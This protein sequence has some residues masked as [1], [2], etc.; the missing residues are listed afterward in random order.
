MCIIPVAL[1]NQN[2]QAFDFELEGLCLVNWT[3]SI[4]DESHRSSR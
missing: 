3:P 2:S 4:H 1:F